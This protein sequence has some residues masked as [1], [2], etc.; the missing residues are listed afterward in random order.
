MQRLLISALTITLFILV[1]GLAAT[2]VQS[3]SAALDW[4]PG[5]FAKYEDNPIMEPQGNGFEAMA[6]F[7]PTVIV[8]DGIFYML[9]RAEDRKGVSYI[10]LAESEDG[11]NFVRHSEPVLS[12]T[13]KYEIWG[14]CEDPRVVIFGDTYYMTYTAYNGYRAKLAL[15]TST[16]LV[17]WEK[18]GVIIPW[19]WSKSGA[20]VPQ[21][22]NGEYVMYFGDSSIWIAYSDDLINWDVVDEPVMKTRPDHFDSRGIEPGPPP[23]VIDQGILLIYN[24]WNNDITYKVGAVLFSKDDPTRVLERLDQPILEPTEG[25]EKAGQISNVVFAS[26]LAQHEGVWYLY[27]GGADKCLNLAIAKSSP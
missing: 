6:V 9:Y 24:G 15:A 11:I 2:A 26:G 19:P 27:Y 21:K 17:H 4:A 5:P 10:G 23:I 18:H 13:E 25:W 20:I 3:P 1:S 8:E 22:I 14:G 16:D 7:N 12:P